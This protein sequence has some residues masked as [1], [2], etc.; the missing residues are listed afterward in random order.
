MRTTLFTLTAL[1]L[2]AASAISVAADTPTGVAEISKYLLLDSRIIASTDGVALRLGKVEKDPHNPLF[3][4]DKP[5][6]VRYDNLYPNVIFDQEEGLYKCWY[7][8][9]I[10]DKAT[11]TATDAIKQKMTYCARLGQVH[12][13][14]M[15]VCY[16]TSKDGIAW[17]K[18]ELGI[19]DYEGSTKN[20]IVKRAVHGVGVFK[21]AHASDPARRYKMFFHRDSMAVCF[22][23][24]GVHWSNVVACPEIEVAGDTHNNAFWD[25]K[26]G[27][28]LGI[29]RLWADGQR[30]VGALDVMALPSFSE[31]MPNVVLEA[32]AYRTPV[33]ATAVGGVP[34]MVADARFGWL[35]P[36][37]DTARLA[38]ALTEALED[39]QE[40]ERRARQAHTVLAKS[41]TV[42]KQAQAWLHASEAGVRSKSAGRREGSSS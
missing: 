40:A 38:G 4:E 7:S 14:E 13:R 27:R 26:S 15:A 30:I 11:S 33:V 18:P 10:V 1:S 5:W 32:F 16:A 24:D 23:P 42:E 41:F 21:D 12:Q 9:F 29:T 22:S 20:N 3:G 17:D 8:P 2:F 34:D 39:R 37:G 28:Y 36:A 31:G 19:C 35:V 25:E 6:E